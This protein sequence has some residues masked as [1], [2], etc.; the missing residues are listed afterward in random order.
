MARF[1]EVLPV[2]RNGGKVKL[3]HW[4][5]DCYIAI[6]NSLND[7]YFK[8]PQHF[9]LSYLLLDT[10]EIVEAEKDCKIGTVCWFWDDEE[11]NGSYDI[12]EKIEISKMHHKKMYY[13]KGCTKLGFLHC[14]PL[15][16]NEK[17][18]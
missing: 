4:K 3:S 18:E 10:W 7:F 9:D 8:G 16:D 15:L 5:K 17:G 2:L 11:E 13:P 6:D 1:E 14:R 12:L